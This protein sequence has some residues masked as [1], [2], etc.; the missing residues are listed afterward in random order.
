MSTKKKK[1][2]TKKSEN[3]NSF[4]EKFQKLESIVEA[5][6]AH[7]GDIDMHIASFE[8][9]VRLAHDLKKQLAKNEILI[10]ELKKK[11]L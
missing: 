4:A 5:L 9:G 6:E 7:D 11:Y 8:E 2:T 1:S 10:E 3:G